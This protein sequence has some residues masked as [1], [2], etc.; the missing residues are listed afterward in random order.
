MRKLALFSG[1]F[2]LSAALF[3]I[4]LWAVIAWY[5]GIPTSESHALLAGLTGS[6]LAINNGL[7]GV[8]GEE[9]LKALKGLFSS[10]AFGLVAGFLICR[11]FITAF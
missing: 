8:N 6:A 7:S 5:F 11:F 4:V 9:W 1:G 10:C 3:S 2:A